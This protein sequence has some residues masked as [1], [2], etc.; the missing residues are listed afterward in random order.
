[1]ARQAWTPETIRQAVYGQGFTLSGLA[2]A[3][4]LNK[5]ACLHAL[6]RRHI[7]GE[8]AIADCLGVP[9]FELWPDRWAPSGSRIDHRVLPPKTT[10]VSK[11]FTRQKREAA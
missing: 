6:N 10:P 7:P 5:K 9:L 3:H 8:K 11:T 1:M 2:V 4:S